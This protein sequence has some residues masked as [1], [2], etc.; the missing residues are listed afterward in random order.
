[1]AGGWDRD[2]QIERRSRPLQEFGYRIDYLWNSGKIA[3]IL[4]TKQQFAKFGALRVENIVAMLVNANM[5]T[6]EGVDIQRV[7]QRPVP[8]NSLRMDCRCH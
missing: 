3:P 7:A 4:Q 8:H 6:V 5:G 1:M 2:N